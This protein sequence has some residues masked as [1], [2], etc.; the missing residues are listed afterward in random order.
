MTQKG[1][2]GGARLRAV[3]VRHVAGTFVFRALRLLMVAAS[4]LTLLDWE[5]QG[6]RT[7]LSSP[8]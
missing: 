4:L 6:P 3:F 5:S 7:L 2:T 1:D 8:L